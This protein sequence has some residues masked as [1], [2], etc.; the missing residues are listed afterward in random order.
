MSGPCRAQLT[1]LLEPL[2]GQVPNRPQQPPGQLAVELSLNLDQGLPR[3]ASTHRS[4]IAVAGA[5]NGERGVEFES[6]HEH[7]QWPQDLPALV[8]E[9][10]RA[11]EN[12]F[13][14]RP[15]PR[16]TIRLGRPEL[17]RVVEQAN[18]VG[19]GPGSAVPCDE[20]QRQGKAVHA[21]RE[22]PRPRMSSSREGDPRRVVCEPFGQQEYGR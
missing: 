2:Q 17:E 15:V 6:A 4:D 21:P 3:E 9:S 22:S 19:D 13:A 8:G 12:R 5:D 18:Q 1:C 16:R 20:F 7:P 14:K 10:V 11:P